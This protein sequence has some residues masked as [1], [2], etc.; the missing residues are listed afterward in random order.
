MKDSLHLGGIVESLLCI[1]WGKRWA[2]KSHFQRK[3]PN[4][5][6]RELAVGEEPRAGGAES[7]LAAEDSPREFGVSSRSSW[8]Q[9]GLGWGHLKASPVPGS[10]GTSGATLAPDLEEGPFQEK[11]QGKRSEKSVFFTSGWI[12]QKVFLSN[13]RL[14]LDQFFRI[15]TFS[16]LIVF[17]LYKFN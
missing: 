8:A 15:L 7:A 4:V 5:V 12:I 11:F 2:I 1:C 14:Y 17:C 6:I 3:R 10:R 13:L 16:S 9:F